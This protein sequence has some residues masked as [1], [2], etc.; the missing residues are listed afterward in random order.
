M[1]II[2]FQILS[3]LIIIFLILYIYNFH[4]KKD[5][6]NHLTN[7]SN[8]LKGRLKKQTDDIIS[9]FNIS[10]TADS[11]GLTDIYPDCTN[12]DF[13]SLL[14]NS[15]KLIILVNDGRT[16]A[17]VQRDRL[18]KRFND[19]QK[20]T[21]FFIIHPDSIMI[22]VLSRKGSIEKD[23][24]KQRIIETL[25]LLNEISVENTKLE[26]L[27]HHLFNPHSMIVSEDTAIL[28]PYFVSRGGRT[29][30]AMKYVNI[31]D[32]EC[33]YKRLFD[34]L[35]KLRM[36]SQSLNVERLIM[37]TKGSRIEKKQT[38]LF[39]DNSKYKDDNR[40]EKVVDISKNKKINRGDSF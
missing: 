4:L 28:I 10:K 17:S 8:I 32:D 33:Y 25:Q 18:R 24:L 29:V 31:D 6:N 23:I 2:M 30:P 35:E 3:F 39:E 13:D 26:I 21:T 9:Q 36:D 1:T 14:V 40:D 22:D 27:G 16:W 34:D 37:K 15:Q 5:F 20:E 7:I 19:P 38:Y 11:M 12:I